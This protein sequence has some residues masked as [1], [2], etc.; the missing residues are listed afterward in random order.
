M[1][2]GVDPR[3]ATHL[4][5]AISASLHLVDL[6]ILGANVA[7]DLQFRGSRGGQASDWPRWSPCFAVI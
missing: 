7:E 6:L 2:A 3:M 1:N 5:F 4:V